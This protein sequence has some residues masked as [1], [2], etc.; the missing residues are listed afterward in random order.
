[1]AT[2]LI[3]GTLG[4][5]ISE[6][7][8]ILNLGIEGTMFLGSFVGFTVASMTGS[9][10]LGFL[11]AVISGVLAGLLMAL[12]TVG[13]GLNQHVSGLGITLF[14]TGISLFAYRLIFGERS[15]QPSISSFPKLSPFGST[16]I[17]GPIFEQYAL[18]FLAFA[19]VPIIWWLIYRTSFGL[20]LRAVGENPEA[21]DAAGVDVFAMRYT[22]LGIA[23][24]LM[25]AGGAFLSLAQLGSFIFGI[26]AGR[27]WVCIALV[28]FANW[29]PVKVF[30]GALLFGGV[31]ALQLRLQATGMKLPYELFLALP[32]LVT[33][34]A[35]TIAGRNAQA[36]AAL[37]KAYRRE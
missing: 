14:L 5:L 15:V 23:G 31:F 8:G 17:L 33:I 11:A 27:G 10:W 20:Q 1:V 6:R 30:W 4:E 37:L 18:T 19:L 16:P 21:G 22:A 36:P 28:I 12:L 29:H 26:V 7:A 9:L 35:L 3:F 32:Y 24:G 25:A 2:P 34:A 13:L